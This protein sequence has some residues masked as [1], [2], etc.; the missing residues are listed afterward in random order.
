MHTFPTHTFPAHATQRAR[1]LQVSWANGDVYHGTWKVMPVTGPNGKLPPHAATPGKK[2]GG[3]GGGSVGVLDS[4]E[5]PMQR[6]MHGSGVFKYAS[7]DYYQV[8]AQVR[9]GPSGPCAAGRGRR[10]V[11]G[12]TCGHDPLPSPC[13]LT[14]LRW[15]L[16]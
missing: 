4:Q 14:P 5:V 8:C 15:R 10:G 3:G 7:G 12:V 11:G 9:F 6:K 1:T 16:A 13:A 2:S